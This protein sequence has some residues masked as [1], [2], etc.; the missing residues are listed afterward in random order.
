MARPSA[1]LRTSAG[2]QERSPS[3]GMNSMKRTWKRRLRASSQKRETSSAPKPGIGTALTL[4]GRTCG[5]AAIASSPSSTRSSA[6]R[7]VTSKKRP[8][9]SESI[10]TLTRSIPAATSASA[11]RASR[12]PVGGGGGQVAVGGQREVAHPLDRRQP[13]DQRRELAPHQRL[14]AGQPHVL[15]P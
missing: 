14:A 11:S 1:P 6:S 5:K 4:I 2:R 10:E 8:R 9:A 3:S 12:R 13:R 7:R 15:D